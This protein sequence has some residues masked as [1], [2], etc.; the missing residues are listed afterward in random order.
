M[1]KTASQIEGSS[2]LYVYRCAS[3]GHRGDRHFPDDSHDGEAST[4][5]ACGDNVTLEWDGGVRLE[6]NRKGK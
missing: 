1:T 3:C 6:I 2:V 5:D 4:C